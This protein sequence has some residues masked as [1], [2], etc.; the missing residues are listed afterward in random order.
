MWRRGALFSEDGILFMWYTL[1]AVKQSAEF[2]ISAKVKTEGDS[3]W[4]SGHFPGEPILPGIAQLGMVADV[5]SKFSK[6]D[7]YIR[8]LSRVK[9]KK[10]SK[11]GDLLSIHAFPGKRKNDYS[12]RI[13]VRGEEVC[14]GVIMLEVK[15]K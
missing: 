8:S 14:S 2:E 3:P 5:I 11:P 7:L 15:E 1:V 9:F 6:D 12:F 13:E 4:Y 10:I